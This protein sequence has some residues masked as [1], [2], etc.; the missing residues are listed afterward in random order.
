[1]RLDKETKILIVLNFNKFDSIDRLQRY[2]KSQKC[3][4]IPHH[5]TIMGV[6][7]RFKQTGSI[8]DLPRL[9]RTK[10]F[11]DEKNLYIHQVLCARSFKIQISQG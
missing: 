10:I 4:N 1:M 6:I 3:K 11:D 5:N 9:G 8:A 2:L 7:K